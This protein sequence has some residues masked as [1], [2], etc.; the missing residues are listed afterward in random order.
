MHHSFDFVCYVGLRHDWGNRPLI[1]VELPN[2]LLQILRLDLVHHFVHMLSSSLVSF[3]P[4][5][6]VVSFLHRRVYFL[7]RVQ[8]R[9]YS[10]VRPVLAAAL[11]SIEFVLEHLQAFSQ[12]VSSTSGVWLTQLLL[13][14]I[15]FKQKLHLN[16]ASADLT[17][18]LRIL[19]LE[20]GHEA[21]QCALDL[22]E[23][24]LGV[25]CVL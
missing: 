25:G 18:A 20:L 21:A 14:L 15:V 24:N 8:N 7:L 5:N 23:G 13:K 10:Q 22:F 1:L 17:L 9:I 12:C 19:Y 11:S 2:L 6:R 3:Q 16:V 4:L